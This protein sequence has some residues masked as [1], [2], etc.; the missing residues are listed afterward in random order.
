MSDLDVNVE[1]ETSGDLSIAERLQAR[2]DRRFQRELEAWGESDVLPSILRHWGEGWPT[3]APSTVA[4]KRRRNFPLPSASS[5][6]PLVGSGRLIAAA[7]K[8]NAPGNIFE[9]KPY[10]LTVGVSGAVLPYAAAQQYGAG[11]IPARPYVRVYQES[12]D[13][14]N[15]TVT[16]ELQKAIEG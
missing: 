15:E 14:L 13:R 1:V 12:L 11:R 9:A 10:S 8:R 4:G 16:E 2:L 6:F 7:T 5:G 3:L